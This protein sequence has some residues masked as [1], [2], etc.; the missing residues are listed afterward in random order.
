MTMTLVETI[1][2]GSGGAA[3]IEF[4]S[5]PQDGTDLLF[6]ASARG[7][8]ADEQTDLRVEFNSDTTQ[9]NYTFLRLVGNGAVA[10]STGNVSIAGIANGDT[11]TSNTFSSHQIYISNYTSSSSKSLSG[12]SVTENN[13]STENTYFQSLNSMLYGPTS[14]I[15]SIKI[16]GGGANLKQ[17]STASLY[18]IS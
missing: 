13:S 10:S 1:E 9:A 5:I 15:T 12:E 11:A 18:K 16:F 4:T 14:A 6:V 2:V 17:Y 7:D 3:S 8:N